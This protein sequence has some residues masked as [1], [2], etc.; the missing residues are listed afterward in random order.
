MSLLNQPIIASLSEEA[1]DLF[2][3][4]FEFVYT[5]WPDSNSKY[6]LR[7]Q[8][9]DF[10]G[11]YVY[12]APSHEVA[13]STAKLLQ[14]TCTSSHIGEE[15]EM[16]TRSGWVWFM[17]LMYPT[18]LEYRSTLVF[19]QI[20]T[21]AIEIVHKLRQERRSNTPASKRCYVGEVQQ[22]SQSLLAS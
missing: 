20:L 3:D 12:F 21:Q 13:D 22:Q 11:D 5:P 8:L 1:A 7:S 17:V 9:A 6:A 15:K 18:S 2:A 19:R 4:A 10:I 14:Y 16:R